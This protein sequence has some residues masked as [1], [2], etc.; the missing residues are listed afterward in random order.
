MHPKYIITIPSFG[1][2]CIGFNSLKNF[3]P[4]GTFCWH[5]C[6]LPCN[7]NDYCRE[8]SGRARDLQL[9]QRRCNCWNCLQLRRVH[10]GWNVFHCRIDGENVLFC[11]S[12]PSHWNER[13]FEVR[14]CHVALNYFIFREN[15]I[16]FCLLNL[17]NW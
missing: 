8:H 17:T 5:F 1:S 14:S 4:P 9:C 7:L 11:P 6:S 3:T 15:S 16:L 2:V 13:D 12:F 10:P